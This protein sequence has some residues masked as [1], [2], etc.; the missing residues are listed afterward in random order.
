MKKVIV[1]CSLAVIILSCPLYALP[2]GFQTYSFHS[3]NQLKYQSGMDCRTRTMNGNYN[4]H[5]TGGDMPH[6]RP[7]IH[8]QPPDSN[9]PV[10]EPTTLA[11]FGLGTLGLGIY[12][13]FSR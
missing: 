7:N 2:T 10:P 4:L 5:G 8:C 1:L 9:S 13:K 6:F 3:P 11:L 12:K